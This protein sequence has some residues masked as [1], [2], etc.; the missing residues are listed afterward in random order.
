MN[1]NEAL[2]LALTTTSPAAPVP[3]P[4]LRPDLVETMRRL[5]AMD[6]RYGR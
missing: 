3:E 5:D 1:K 6:G 2:D 4:E